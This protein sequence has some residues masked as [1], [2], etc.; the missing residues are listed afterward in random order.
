MTK[1]LALTDY[2]EQAMSLAECT[3]LETGAVSCRVNTLGW[4]HMAV[5]GASLDDTRY[6]LRARLEETC[7]QILQQGRDLPPLTA[8]DRD[9][10]YQRSSDVELVDAL[11]HLF[12]VYDSEGGFTHPAEYTRAAGSPAGGLLYAA[13]FLPDF[14]EIDGMIFL[15]RGWPLVEYTDE[16][17]GFLGR[18]GGDRRETEWMLNLT[19]VG[20]LFR[21]GEFGKGPFIT[22]ADEDWLLAQLLAE[23][24][25]GRLQRLHPGRAFVVEV[26]DPWTTHVDSISVTVYSSHGS[27]G[28]TPRKRRRF[29]G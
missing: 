12:A 4:R 19:G 15:D 23:A 29:L 10:Q 21:P 3:H 6:E 7:R 25:R 1:R 26:V 22:T 17:L 28:A 5:V 9:R 14:I 24:W 27:D 18:S 20:G 13:V 16:V 2:F 11:K 8:D